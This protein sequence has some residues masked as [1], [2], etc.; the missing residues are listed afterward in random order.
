VRWF[1]ENQPVTSIIDTIRNL[2][3]EQPVESDVW[4]ALGWCV[5]LLVVSY[6][7]AMATYRRKTR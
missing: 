4:V 2:F 6:T 5:G 3:A 7:L 1:A